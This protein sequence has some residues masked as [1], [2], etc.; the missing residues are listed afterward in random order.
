MENQEKK[1][2]WRIWLYLTP[3][4][5]LLLWPLARWSMQM[6]AG[7]LEMSQEDY[8][9]F[10]SSE[11]EIKD[12]GELTEPEFVDGVLRVRYRTGGE[13]PQESLVRSGNS[14]SRPEKG[15]GSARPSS[16]SGG[17]GKGSSGMSAARAAEAGI[18]RPDMNDI[19]QREQMSVG[20]Q[21]GYLT[22]A[23]G[24]AMK[25]PKAVKALLNNKYV[26]AG[27]M[28]RD[29]VKRATSSPEA[30]KEYLKGN[31]PSNFVNNPVVKAAMGNPDVVSAV[32][33]SGMIGA[34]LDTPAARELM[35]DPAAVAELVNSNPDLIAMAMQDPMLMSSLMSNPEV[36]GIV[37]KFDTSLVKGS[38]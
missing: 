27:F 24:A 2:G 19:R 8:G 3:V 21:T 29:T 31:G 18:E 6:K 28:S 37:Y 25:S 13:G 5:L 26:V 16:G 36:S 22:K 34:L 4:Y 17:S 11:G 1:S 7:D 10:A 33:S 20:H 38:R 14:S 32:A 12:W 23:V 9:A 30:L 35:K 15:S